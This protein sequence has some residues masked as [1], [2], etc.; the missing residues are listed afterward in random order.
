MTSIIKADNI[1]TVAGTG[2]ISVAAGNTI[3]Q[4]GMTLQIATSTYDGVVSTSANGSPSLSTGIQLFSVSF[5]PK[6]ATSLILVQTSTISIEEIANSGDKGW[7]GL[8]DGDTF[9]AANSGG[10]LYTHFASNLNVT[11][12]S[13]NNSWIAGSTSTRT[14]QVRA[15]FDGGTAY[16][17][18]NST[19]NYTGNAA[20]IQMTVWEIAQ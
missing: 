2:T 20:R 18:G 1:S 9:I 4:P 10:P 16:I 8:F 15:G 5:T 6:F 19:Y 3:V 7:L 11:H 17:N 12:V 14:I 13:L